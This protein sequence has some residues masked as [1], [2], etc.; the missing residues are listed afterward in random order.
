MAIR[1][2]QD[3]AARALQ[4]SALEQYE[5]VAMYRPDLLPDLATETARGLTISRRALRAATMQTYADL[6]KRYPK[7]MRPKKRG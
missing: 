3:D 1:K 4:G 6:L 5:F 2:P 7:M